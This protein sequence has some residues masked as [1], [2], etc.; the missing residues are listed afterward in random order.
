M[1]TIKKQNKFKCLD[2]VLLGGGGLYIT[3]LGRAGPPEVIVN[4][5]KNKLK[6][7]EKPAAN[8][9]KPRKAEVNFCPSHP[10]G[11]TTDSLEVKGLLY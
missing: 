6:G 1:C 4:S 3:K 10:R 8:I 9:K 7:Q 2:F 11:E 5:L